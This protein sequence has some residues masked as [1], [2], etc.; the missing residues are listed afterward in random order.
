MPSKITTTHSMKPR[1]TQR[2]AE[3]NGQVLDGSS[4]GLDTASICRLTELKQTEEWERYPNRFRHLYETLPPENVWNHCREWPESEIKLLIQEN[5]NPQDLIVYTDGSV[6][7][8]Q[9]GW[10]FI[11]KQKRLYLLKVTEQGEYRRSL[12]EDPDEDV[13]PHPGA[14]VGQERPGAANSVDLSVAESRH[15][16]LWVVVNWSDHWGLAKLAPHLSRC[17]CYLTSFRWCLSCCCGD[18]AVTSC[19]S[20][21]AERHQERQGK[22]SWFRERLKWAHD[23]THEWMFCLKRFSSPIQ[24]APE[25]SIYR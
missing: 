23:Y 24:G 1:K 15:L 8:G 2:D 10:G 7:T 25:M 16:C 20:S 17:S 14:L 5:S 9:L 4:R 3:W 11:V 21:G 22:S 19:S 18:G 13:Y 12:C 6:T